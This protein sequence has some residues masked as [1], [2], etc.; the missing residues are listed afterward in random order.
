M[1]KAIQVNRAAREVDRELRQLEVDDLPAVTAVD[2]AEFPKDLWP[3]MDRLVT[4]MRRESRCDNVIHA[5]ASS[6]NKLVRRL[7]RC[8]YPAS[9]PRFV[10]LAGQ[11]YGPEY[12]NRLSANAQGF[13]PH[14]LHSECIEESIAGRRGATRDGIREVA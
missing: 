14:K 10:S 8:M 4:L 9:T 6:R 11:D 3:K 2:S 5:L 1:L 13:L 7:G 12:L